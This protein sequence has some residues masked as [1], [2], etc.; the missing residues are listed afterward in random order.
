MQMLIIS[1]IHG[2]LVALD[3]VLRKIKVD[4]II[5]LGD[6]VDYGPMPRECI[7]LIKDMKIP[8]VRGNH[9]NAVANRIDCGC[10]Y[11][12]KHLS[13]ITREFTFQELQ[14]Q[15]ISFLKK[16]PLSLTETIDGHK[17]YFTHGSPNSMY[18]YIRP[19]TSSDKIKNMLE[20]VEADFVFI[21]HS[22][23]PFRRNI[24]SKTIINAGSVGQPRDG[25]SRTCCIL[26]DTVSLNFEIIRIEYDVET[27]FNQIRNKKIP[28][29]D[30]LV[31][32]LRRGY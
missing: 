12:Y 19:E 25:D 11:E 14:Q 26:F 31:S 29:S 2:N 10:G 5:C 23:V 8:T 9:D 28:N 18:E 30:E 4:K 7:E 15:H 20:D 32:I 6:L 17:Y 13:Q 3:T 24:D 21:G 1:D 27:V 16:L 22:H